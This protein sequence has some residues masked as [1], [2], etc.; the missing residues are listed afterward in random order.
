MTMGR[1][2]GPW[3]V[4]IDRVLVLTILFLL[5]PW[6]VWYY[7]VTGTLLAVPEVLAYFWAVR[8]MR[9]LIRGA[10]AYG[11][12]RLADMGPERTLIVFKVCTSIC[13]VGGTGMLM[14]AWHAAGRPVLALAFTVGSL[15]FARLAIFFAEWLERIG[16]LR[17][18]PAP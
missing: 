14:G 16:A 6:A 8:T 1:R 13:I 2:K 3:T 4:R 18:P 5:V 15:L 10:A 7:G 9:S 11:D 17:D 12:A